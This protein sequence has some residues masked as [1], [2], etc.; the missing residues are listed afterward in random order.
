MDWQP[1]ETA[2]RDGTEILLHQAG[3]GRVML[4][5]RGSSMWHF[6]DEPHWSEALQE[7]IAD[8]NGWPD[9][10]QGPTHWMPLPEP[11]K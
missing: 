2:P 4:G 5:W 8:I 1:I 11:P 6:Y 3:W 10:K 7:D 9:D